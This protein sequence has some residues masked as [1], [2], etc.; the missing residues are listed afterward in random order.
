MDEF[1]R[2]WLEFLFFDEALWPNFR[3]SLEVLAISKKQN[4]DHY[5]SGLVRGFSVFQRNKCRL[6][7]LWFGVRDGSVE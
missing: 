7:L 4:S 6:R 3:I 1:F 5:I 2:V